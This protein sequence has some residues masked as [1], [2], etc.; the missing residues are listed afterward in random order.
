MQRLV[1]QGLQGLCVGLLLC[2]VVAQAHGETPDLLTLK[3]AKDLSGAC[4]QLADELHVRLR[5]APVGT[6]ATGEPLGCGPLGTAPWLLRL[7]EGHAPVIQLTEA[8]LAGMSAH[9]GKPTAPILPRL[10]ALET[11][12]SL[13]IVD[14]F[15]SSAS[16]APPPQRADCVPG[17]QAP[18]QWLQ[19]LRLA[20]MPGAAAAVPMPSAEQYICPMRDGH[21]VLLVDGQGRIGRVGISPVGLQRLAAARLHT[22]GDLLHAMQALVPT[23]LG[24]AIRDGIQVQITYQ[25]GGTLS[26]AVGNDAVSYF[27]K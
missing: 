5:L 21:G 7:D 18:A 15:S 4:A 17:V 24:A 11:A 12:Q 6:E 23:E 10:L 3:Q 9:A 14:D 8:G 27:L 25:R 26:L 22:P 1:W 13:V 20:G 19:L 2:G 16:M